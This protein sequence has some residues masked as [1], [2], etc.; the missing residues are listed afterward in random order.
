MM[1]E[2]SDLRLNRWV[3]EGVHVLGS[4]HDIVSLR[5]YIRGK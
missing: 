3:Q 5:K 1:S 2:R 4:P